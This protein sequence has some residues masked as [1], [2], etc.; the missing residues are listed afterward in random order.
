MSY[1][2][3]IKQSAEKE[4]DQLPKQ[5]FDRIISIILSLE[6]L[7]RPDGCVKLRNSDLYRIRVG[8]YRILFCID[9]NKK[10]IEIVSVG[11]RRDVYRGK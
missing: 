7:P 8:Q 9:D 1:Q 5:L 4:L 10:E 11:H 2:I 6:E 3:S